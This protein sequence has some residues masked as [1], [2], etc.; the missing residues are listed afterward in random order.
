MN[1]ENITNKIEHAKNK[2]L[3][4]IIEAFEEALNDYPEVDM[5]DVNKYL[6]NVKTIIKSNIL[7]LNNLDSYL[8]TNKNLLSEEKTGWVYQ[9]IFVLK[10]AYSLM[11][12]YNLSLEDV[13]EEMNRLQRLKV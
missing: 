11:K 6:E 13:L 4:E 1:I 2:Q 9:S 10:E 5:F 7:T 12:K 3:K 8:N